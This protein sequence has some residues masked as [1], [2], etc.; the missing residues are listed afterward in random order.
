MQV[1]EIFYEN[2]KRQGDQT[3]NFVF[4]PGPNKLV[5]ILSINIINIHDGLVM[6]AFITIIIYQ[7]LYIWYMTDIWCMMYSRYSGYVYDA[8]WLYARVLDA[9]IRKDKSLVQVK[10]ETTFHNRKKH[11]WITKTYLFSK[12]GEWI[13]NSAFTKCFLQPPTIVWSNL[14]KHWILPP[15][16]DVTWTNI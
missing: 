3:K 6:I 16:M 15:Q 7:I 14:R 13:Q 8:V 4:H 10:K 5:S 1:L 9:L 12:K 11:H 2:Y